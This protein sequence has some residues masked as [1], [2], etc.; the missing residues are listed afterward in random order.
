MNAKW[1]LILALYLTEGSDTLEQVQDTRCEYSR[2]RL[3]VVYAPA[4]YD[5][6]IAK[7]NQLSANT[8]F[9]GR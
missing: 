4:Q 2:H 3:Y 6:G 7:S 5:N 8:A 9:S 1:N